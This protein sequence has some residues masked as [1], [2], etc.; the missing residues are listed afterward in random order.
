MLVLHLFNYEVCGI[1]KVD[2][3]FPRRHTLDSIYLYS[4]VF[5]FF[6]NNFG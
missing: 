1:A 4:V 2:I 3:V 5:F 6:R